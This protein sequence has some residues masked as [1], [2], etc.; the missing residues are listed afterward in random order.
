MR[1]DSDRHNF[2]LPKDKVFCNVM[3][4]IVSR[5][6]NGLLS[7]FCSN[8]GVGRLSNVVGLILFIK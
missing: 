2:F 5:I 6:R 8:V 7:C 4:N 3:V 1:G